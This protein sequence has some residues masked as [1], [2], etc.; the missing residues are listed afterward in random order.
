MDIQVAISGSEPAGLL[1]SRLLNLAG[2]ANI[3]LERRSRAVAGLRQ[4]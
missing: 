3:V 4:V 1:L 2:I